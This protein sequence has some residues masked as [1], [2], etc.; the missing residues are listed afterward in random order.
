MM[1]QCVS[2]SDQRF[3]IA[4]LQLSDWAGL[5]IGYSRLGQD[6]IVSLCRSVFCLH[7][8]IVYDW[9]GIPNSFCGLYLLFFFCIFCF[10][11]YWFLCFNYWI[12]FFCCWWY[13]FLFVFSAYYSFYSL[14][15]INDFCFFLPI[16]YIIHNEKNIL[17]IQM[18]R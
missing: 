3:W 10:G 13:Y 15:L 11:C 4:G 5:T 16:R 18:Y 9:L 12:L 14:V 7:F 17:L 1:C 8:F 6:F 2:N